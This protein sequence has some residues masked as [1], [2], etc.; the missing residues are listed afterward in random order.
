MKFEWITD[1][2][3]IWS[4][5]FVNQWHTWMETSENAHVFFHPAMV[6]AWVRYLY[7]YPMTFVR[8]FAL[9]H[10]EILLY[11]YP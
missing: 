8:C 4:D 5:N 10:M 11:F 2:E 9:Q 1:W 3:T 6:R 7:A